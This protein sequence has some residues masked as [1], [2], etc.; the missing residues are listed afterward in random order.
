MLFAIV[1]GRAV[2]DA[3]ARE[4]FAAAAEELRV[5]GSLPGRGG[6]PALRSAV[7]AR[8]QGGAPE[9]DEQLALALQLLSS[10]RRV[11]RLVAECE[12]LLAASA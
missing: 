8:Q 6:G 11:K 9:A 10:R 5:I 4:D 2:V 3:Y 7:A 1:A 12:S